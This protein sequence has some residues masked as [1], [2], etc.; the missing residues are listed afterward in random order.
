MNFGEMF[1]HVGMALQHIRDQVRGWN[2]EFFYELFCL[3]G[4]KIDLSTGDHTQSNGRTERG[5][6][7]IMTGPRHFTAADQ[8][9]WD[10][11]YP[12]VEFAINST[13]K[14]NIYCTPCD[15]NLTAQKLIR[16]YDAAHGSRT[17]C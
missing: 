3:V 12:F 10:D 9:N 17:N 11:G 2:N 16:C 8:R 13:Y 14:E 1:P 15:T 4:V 6:E 7:V 5:N